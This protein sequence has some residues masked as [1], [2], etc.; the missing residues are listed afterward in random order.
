MKYARCVKCRSEL[1]QTTGPWKHVYERAS[2]GCVLEV[3]EKSVIE[4]ERW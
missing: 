4:I 2:P 3:D 1:I